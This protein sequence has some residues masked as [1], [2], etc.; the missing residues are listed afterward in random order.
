LVSVCSSSVASPT[1]IIDITLSSWG[2]ASLL[3]LLA[4]LDR[5]QILEDVNKQRFLIFYVCFVSVANKVHVNSS[6]AQV[7]LSIL[8]IAEKG[9]L[10]LKLVKIFGTDF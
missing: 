3:L 6:T 7:L 8:L 5:I 4:F 2:L 1:I 10:F 9:F